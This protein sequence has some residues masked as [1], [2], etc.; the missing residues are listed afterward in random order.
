MFVKLVVPPGSS[1]VVPESGLKFG[2]A[3]DD[4]VLGTLDNFPA[5]SLSSMISLWRRSRA[6]RRSPAR[7]T[8]DKKAHPRG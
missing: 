2:A 8:L 4:L 6:S 7:Q 1:A 5:P 3:V